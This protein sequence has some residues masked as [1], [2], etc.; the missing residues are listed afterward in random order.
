MQT[1]I[2]IHTVMWKQ[3]AIIQQET[4]KTSLSLPTE[5]VNVKQTDSVG[6]TLDTKTK[7]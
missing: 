4:T 6:N 5:E 2:T 3:T 1:H 7:D